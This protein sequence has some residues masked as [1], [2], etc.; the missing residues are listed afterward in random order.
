MFI[1][2][3]LSVIERLKSLRKYFKR[4]NEYKI[5]LVVDEG[6][7]LESGYTRIVKARGASRVRFSD[8]KLSSSNIFLYHK[9]T[10]RKLYDQEHARWRKKGYFD[11]IFTNEKKQITEGAI[12]NII[13]KKGR[14]YYTPPVECG[15]LNGVFRRHLLKGKRLSIK[16]KILYRQ[17]IKKADEIYMINSVR[18][19]VRVI[20]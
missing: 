19:M 7:N 16:E 11:I 5:R 12:S 20:L 15:L 17:D 1:L 3:V 9:T 14:F 6:G 10:D 13:I 18:G 4:E 2:I 8:R